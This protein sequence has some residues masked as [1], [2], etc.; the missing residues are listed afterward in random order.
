MIVTRMV[1]TQSEI[2]KNEDGTPVQ[3]VFRSSSEEWNTVY[4]AVAGQSEMTIPREDLIAL[5]E[6]LLGT[7][8]EV[9]A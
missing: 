9:P 1:E 5:A 7:F 4:L 6:R 3:F 2:G 8:R